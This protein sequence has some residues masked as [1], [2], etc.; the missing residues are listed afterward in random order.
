MT[1]AP[2]HPSLPQND[3]PQQQAARQAQLASSQQIYVWTDAI[4]TLPDVPAVTA[5]PTADEPTLEWFLKLGG[6]LLGLARNQLSVKLD[7]YGRIATGLATV[8]ARDA[9]IAFEI[10]A[11]M[12]AAVSAIMVSQGFRPSGR[13]SDLAGRERVLLFQHGQK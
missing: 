9:L 12:A 6:I 7:A 4:P 8:L 1:R 2:I 13:R 5:V 10:G 3:S 11:G